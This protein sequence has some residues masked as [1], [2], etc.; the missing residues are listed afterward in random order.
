[1]N[2]YHDK[3]YLKRVT[4]GIYCSAATKEFPMSQSLIRLP[5]AAQEQLSLVLGGV[6]AVLVSSL[7]YVALGLSL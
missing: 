6:S 1:M 2:Y 5:E 4:R 3:P 7:F